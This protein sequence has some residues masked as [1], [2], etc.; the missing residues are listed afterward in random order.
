MLRI[1]LLFLDM[2]DMLLRMVHEQITLLGPRP[3]MLSVPELGKK[4]KVPVTGNAD[5]VGL[6]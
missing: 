6:K 3:A 5:Y 2:T 4:N 1:V